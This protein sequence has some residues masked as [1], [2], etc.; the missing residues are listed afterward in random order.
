MGDQ[1]GEKLL[2]VLQ[3]IAE[4]CYEHKHD[5][6]T[7]K[8]CKK[9]KEQ[10]ERYGNLYYMANAD[11][12]VGNISLRKGEKQKGVEILQ[13]AAILFEKAEDFA[14]VGQINFQIGHV[15]QEEQ[16][17]ES[18]CLFYLEAIKAYQNAI[19]K[20]HPQRKSYWSL[21]QNLEKTIMELKSQISNLL[22][23]IQAPEVKEKLLLDLEKV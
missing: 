13:N 14:G 21:P 3:D 9:L 17:Y 19:H 11:F 15:H 10:A 8:Y 4:L 6:L 2:D 12:Y 22:D 18:T 23:K 5:N 16:D 1:Y 7:I 20:F